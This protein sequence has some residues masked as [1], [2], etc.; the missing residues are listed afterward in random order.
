MK[1]LAMW[2]KKSDQIIKFSRSFAKLYYFQ[3]FIQCTQFLSQLLQ[4]II[5]IQF[6]QFLNFMTNIQNNCL[7]QF[8]R[9]QLNSLQNS[10]IFQVILHIGNLQLIFTKIPKCK[11]GYLT[12]KDLQEQEVL[13][14]I[15]KIN[16]LIKTRQ[17]IIKSIRF[18]FV[19]VGFQFSNDN[20]QIYVE[21][22]NTLIVVP[23]VH[24]IQQIYSYTLSAPDDDDFNYI[25]KVQ[26]CGDCKIVLSYG[27]RIIGIN[28]L[29]HQQNIM[30]QSS[31]DLQSFDYLEKLNVLVC[32]QYY[33]ILCVFTHDELLFKQRLQYEMEEISFLQTQDT[34]YQCPQILF[35]NGLILSF[36]YNQQQIYLFPKHIIFWTRDRLIYAYT[37]N[38]ENQ[39]NFQQKELSL[40]KW[41]KLTGR[42]IL[43]NLTLYSI[44]SELRKII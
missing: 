5:F 38:E 25:G 17:K 13:Q 21:C 10:G 1:F 3:G 19:I 33:G 37:L 24:S 23:L 6:Y 39:Q 36:I 22:R 31:I 11:Q 42:I 41:I 7:Q 14:A 35:K 8:E 27:H 9:I 44:L 34:L 12:I 29:T 15:Q 32:S 4:Q 20:H 26:I 2:G 18:D 40:C 30:F 16:I 28:I 43:T